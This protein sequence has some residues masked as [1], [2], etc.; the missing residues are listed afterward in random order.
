M[1]YDL[2]MKLRPRRQFGK[3]LERLLLAGGISLTS[4]CAQT[5]VHTSFI[6]ESITASSTPE[7]KVEKLATTPSSKIIN[8]TEA[9]YEDG[10]FLTDG[11]VVEVIEGQNIP[12]FE[13]IAEDGSRVIAFGLVM[14]KWHLK[15]RGKER[16][17]KYYIPPPAGWHFCNFVDEQREQI[18]SVSGAKIKNGRVIPKWDTFEEIVSYLQEASLRPV[19]IH[20]AEGYLYRYPAQKYENV[21]VKPL[22]ER[23]IFVIPEGGTKN[24]PKTWKVNLNGEMIEVDAMP[25]SEVQKKQNHRLVVTDGTPCSEIR[26]N[27]KWYP[28]EDDLGNIQAEAGG[29]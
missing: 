6:F 19:S 4:A 18:F 28:S 24:T 9:P 14:E 23:I 12:T 8:D 5:R 21:K 16:N 29:I 15:L 1:S 22:E 2:K 3:T 20:E 7:A 17:T 27:W 25:W 13:L 11:E 10:R 26:K